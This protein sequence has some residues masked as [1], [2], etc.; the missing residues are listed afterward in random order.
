MLR[1]MERA[2][3]SCGITSTEPIQETDQLIITQEWIDQGHCASLEQLNVVILP[4]V[5]IFNGSLMLTVRQIL[6]RP[7][8]S[9]S[10]AHNLQRK[11]AAITVTPQKSTYAPHFR[12]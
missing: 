1:Y 12:T 7:G 4:G 2:V 5:T 6:D 9:L 10:S 11:M 3:I 8:Y